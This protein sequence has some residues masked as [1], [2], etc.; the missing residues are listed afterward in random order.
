MKNKHDTKV[1][2]Q[3][4]IIPH[5]AKYFRLSEEDEELSGSISGPVYDIEYNIYAGVKSRKSH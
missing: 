5:T 4:K 1:E 3:N 2:K